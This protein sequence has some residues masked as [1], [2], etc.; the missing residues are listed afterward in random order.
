MS[1]APRRTT[2]SLISSSNHNLITTPVTVDSMRTTTTNR[3]EIIISQAEVSIADYLQVDS[4]L[5]F[6]PF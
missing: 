4:R 3:M 1:N 6:Y 2:L 5:C